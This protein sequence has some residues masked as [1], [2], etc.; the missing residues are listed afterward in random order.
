MKRLDNDIISVTH[1]RMMTLPIIQTSFGKNELPNDRFLF[2]GLCGQDC[3]RAH[4]KGAVCS[5]FEMKEVNNG[6]QRNSTY[7]PLN[8]FI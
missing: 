5:R 8:G 6:P 2:L 7:F 3:V 1:D 4:F